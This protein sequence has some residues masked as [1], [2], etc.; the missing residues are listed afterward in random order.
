MVDFEEINGGLE[1]KN[2]DDFMHIKA[3]FI[4]ETI[5][6]RVEVNAFIE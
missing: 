1:V 4:I 3:L 6:R 5:E 2:N